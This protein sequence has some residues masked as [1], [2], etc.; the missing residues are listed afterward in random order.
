MKEWKQHKKLVDYR[1][2]LNSGMHGILKNVGMYE[3]KI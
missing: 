1:R 3:T 2:I